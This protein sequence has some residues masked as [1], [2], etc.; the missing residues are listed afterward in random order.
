MRPV[1]V[2]RPEPGASATFA[3]A[4]AAGLQ[5]IPAPIFTLKS[6][7]WD[8]PAPREHDALMLTSANAV[9]HAG[10]ALDLYRAL[11]AYAVGEATAVAASAAGFA[12]VRVGASDAAALIGLM[13]RDGVARPL[14]LA[15]RDRKSGA[16]P[17]PIARRIV[18]AA[19]PVAALPGAARAALGRGAVTLVHS[20]RAGRLFASLLAAAELS[21]LTVSIAAISADAASGS[22]KEAAIAATPDD[23]AL[24]A[25]AL[26]LCDKAP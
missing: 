8:A 12:D 13:A 4:T 14:H 7:A 1:L 18:Y 3:R 20:P 11:P 16:A 26:S 22:W 19:D 25:A 24:L 6:V 9:R 2:L 17:F 15:G 10:A 5:A 23:A 21:P